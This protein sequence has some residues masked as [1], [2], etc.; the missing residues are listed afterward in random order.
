MYFDEGY[1]NS[2]RFDCS[3]KLFTHVAHELMW[4]YEYKDISSIAGIDY[5]CIRHL[6]ETIFLRFYCLQSMHYN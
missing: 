2:G 6:K 1:S 3:S 5:I 4:Y